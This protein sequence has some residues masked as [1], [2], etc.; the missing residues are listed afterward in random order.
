MGEGVWCVEA[1]SDGLYP[2]LCRICCLLPVRVDDDVSLWAS[3]SVS[4]VL[5]AC[6]QD[7][8]PKSPEHLESMGMA[9]VYALHPHARHPSLQCYLWEVGV[10]GIVLKRPAFSCVLVEPTT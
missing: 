6:Q 8:R 10:A 3:E 2:Q 4:Q 5:C 9:S 7:C 1:M